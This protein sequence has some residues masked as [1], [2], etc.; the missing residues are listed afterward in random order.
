MVSLFIDT[1]GQNIA[2]EMG[3]CM[4]G[5]VGVVVEVACG[6]KVWSCSS[7]WDC[8]GWRGVGGSIDSI[9]FSME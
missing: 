8:R 9:G 1:V 3:C 6:S 2:F 7:L 5:C 4:D